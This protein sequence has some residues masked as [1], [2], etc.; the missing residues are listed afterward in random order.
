MA[1]RSYP[2]LGGLAA[3]LLAA[4]TLQVA[5]VAAK[6]HQDN[7]GDRG[8]DLVR[9]A[10]N[11]AN[12]PFQSFVCFSE[13]STFEQCPADDLSFTVPATTGSG[14]AVKRFVFEH[15]SGSCQSASGIAITMVQLI[16]P[17]GGIGHVLVPVNVTAYPTLENDYAF[18]QQVRLYASP[19]QSVQMGIA[20]IGG[21]NDWCF[22]SFSG[23]FVTQ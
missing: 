20:R 22:M 23:Y 3:S 19:G 21:P 18:S 14:K 2:L 9:D 6:D 4:L 15:L 10:D 1:Q 12:E 5:P 17:Q 8:P 11:P 7:D 13:G 16:I